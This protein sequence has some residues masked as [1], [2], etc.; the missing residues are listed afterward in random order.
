VVIGTSTVLAGP[1]PAAAYAAF[2]A[3]MLRPK[4]RFATVIVLAGLG[5]KDRGDAQGLL[6]N[7]KV[8]F[9]DPSRS[10]DCPPRPTCKPSTPWPRRFQAKHAGFVGAAYRNES[11]FDEV[12]AYQNG[13]LAAP[14]RVLCDTRMY[15]MPF[16][17]GGILAQSS[18]HG[19]H[20]AF[21]RR[22]SSRTC[23]R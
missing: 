20:A 10:R 16:G 17:Q 22:R 1:H 2:V 18:H 13:T 6:G 8:E 21:L 15:L 23:G 3:N 4:A 5:G 9:L 19:G 7:L 11:L 12:L 14:M